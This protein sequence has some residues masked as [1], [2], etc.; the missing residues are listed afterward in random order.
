MKCPKC[1]RSA[2]DVRD[3]PTWNRKKNTSAKLYVH[4]R[5]ILA[6][7]LVP[8]INLTNTCLVVKEKP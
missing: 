5:N 2:I 8:M 6:C 1:G 7:G 3:Y 4:E